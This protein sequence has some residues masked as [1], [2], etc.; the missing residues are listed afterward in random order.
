MVK[1][2]ALPLLIFGTA[3]TNRTKVGKI[4][5]T[6][7]PPAETITIVDEERGI[8]ITLPL[9]KKNS[10]SEKPDDAVSVVLNNI[11]TGK[12]K[13]KL[14]PAP[15]KEKNPWWQ[16]KEIEQEVEVK[17]DEEVVLENSFPTAFAGT[18]FEIIA[19]IHTPSLTITPNYSAMLGA[20][21]LLSTPYRDTIGVTAGYFEGTGEI[22]VGL[23][24]FFW[25]KYPF[26]LQYTTDISY[27]FNKKVLIS[28]GLNIGISIF[29]TKLNA[30]NI[31]NAETKSLSGFEYDIMAGVMIW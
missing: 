26:W 29:M 21:S 17:E 25:I 28:L 14:K 9:I 7:R 2:L 22:G 27:R 24:R 3:E 23:R 30:R 15:T 20:F 31:W 8:K 16:Y 18:S 1:I 10:Q 6:V 12:Y 5:I 19:G 13:I 11:P 4:A